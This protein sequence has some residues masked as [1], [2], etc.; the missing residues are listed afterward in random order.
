MKNG[1]SG[2]ILLLGLILPVLTSCLSSEHIPPPSGFHQDL[3]TKRFVADDPR[4]LVIQAWYPASGIGEGILDPV[5]EKKQAAAYVTF[6]P[7]SEREFRNRLPSDSYLDADMDLSSAPYPVIIFDH[8]YGAFEKQNLSQ[9]EQLASNGYIVFSI[10]H[11]GETAVTLYPDGS[12]IQADTERYP[13]MTA[14]TEK[15]RKER[16]ALTR[17]FFE[18][19]QDS[20]DDSELVAAMRVFSSFS[21]IT[22][23]A[24]PI[25]ERT[26]DVLNFME[27]LVEMNQVGFFKDSMDLENVGMYG[28]SMGGNVS[29][30]V[31]SMD[32]WPINLRAVAN[33]DGPQLLFPEDPLIVL[34]VP[35]LIAY[36]TI[37]YTGGEE[38]DLSGCNDWI[39]NLSEKETWRAVFNGAA[40]ANFSDLTY[41]KILEGKATGDIDGREMGLAQERLLLA[42]FDK[43]LKGKIVETDKLE[44]SYELWDLSF[45]EKNERR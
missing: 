19:Y 34:K 32:S 3:G 23:L 29:N 41:L 10:N 14:D 21:Y 35:A 31:G 5:M 37:A 1:F 12:I 30:I 42:W 13:S 36:G 18:I 38:L 33:L 28:H 43:H 6:L 40:H 9:M 27:N 4:G 11:P 15:E 7:M 39:L 8:G 44:E 22:P 2:L 17:E 24:L 25:S 45:N 26:Q 20:T 16:E